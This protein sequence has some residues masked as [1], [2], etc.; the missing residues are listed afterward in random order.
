MPPIAAFKA[1]EEAG[2]PEG[3]EH[4]REH[5]RRARLAS[6]PAVGS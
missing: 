1:T 6:R 2:C 5:E 3:E 4:Q